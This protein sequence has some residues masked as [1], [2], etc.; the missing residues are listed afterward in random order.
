MWMFFMVDL[1]CSN[2]LALEVING[3]NIGIFCDGFLA[4]TCE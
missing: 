2:P 4:I 1:T 3:M